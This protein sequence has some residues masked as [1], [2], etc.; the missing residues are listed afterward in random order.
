MANF[1]G[2][3]GALPGVIAE[4]ETNTRGQSIPGATRTAALMG[5]GL[6]VERLINSAVGGGNDGLNSTYSSKNGR[7]GRHFLLSSV[8]VVSNRTVLF[9]NGVPLVGVE[10]PVSSTPVG[11]AYDYRLD[12]ANGQIELKGANLVDL[13]GKLYLASTSNQGNGTIGTL[14]L[15]DKNAPTETWTVRCLSVRKD[16][17]GAPIDGYAKFIAQGS[18]SGVPLDGYGNQITWSSNGVLVSN[19]VLSFSV[20]EGTNKFNIGDKFTVKV[21][22]GA[23]TAGESLVANYIAITD[24]NDPEFFTDINLLAAKHGTPSLTNRLSLGAQLAFAN[25]PPGVWTVQTAPAIPRRVSYLLEQSASGNAA[26]NDLSFSLPLDVIPDTNSN[27]NL[28]V[29]DPVTGIET[30]L[31]PNKVAFY[32]AS[33]STSPSL[34]HFGALY[35]FS[36]TVVLDK[37]HDVIAKRVDGVLTAGKLSSATYTFTAT[38]VTSGR[39]VRILTPNVNAG[40]YTI[41]SVNLGVATLT[42]LSTTSSVIEFE[43]LEAS[44]NST[45][46]V[47]FTKDLALSAGS[48][49]RATIVDQRDAT[50]FDVG[51]AAAYEALEIIQTNIVVPLPSQTIS[52]IFASGAAHV[53]AMSQPKIKR[54]RHLYIGAI[55]GLKPEHVTG[56]TPA[57][58]EDVGVLEG[59]QG[60]DVSEVLSGNTE[61]LTNYGAQSAFGNTFRVV[62]FYPDEIVVQIG[63]DRV[64]VDG[65]FMAAAA[66]GYLSSVAS[67]AIPLTNKVLAGF[68]ILRNRMFR[69]SVEETIANAGI[70]LVRPVAGGGKVVWGRTTTISGFP[71]EE[72]ISIVFIRDRIAELMRKGFE[73]Y[74]GVAEDD[75]TL[76]SMSARAIG[77]FKSFRGSLITS[78]SDVKVVK[79]SVDPRQYNVV[80]NVVPRYGIN[81]VYIKIGIGTN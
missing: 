38:D 18:V 73:G 58:V 19:G 52:A 24:L 26:V 65:F 43:V 5:E 61:D 22:G 76:G 75:T 30:Q 10:E 62:Y 33:I 60:D 68:T 6:R 32:D 20:S 69:P 13:G 39:S 3:E 59:I 4:V 51:W 41:A 31:V 23:L 70:C 40:V 63:A 29:K 35:N 48:S 77:L 27:I 50:F 7:D 25:S 8:P 81:N 1:P 64:F 44:T 17:Y 49:L 21:A 66:A 37:V 53:K 46:R 9:K 14:T 34:F 55:R 47:L 67:V 80:G 42:G 54:E 79:D 15:Q 57:A 36:Y 78:F 56:V 28:F 12:I 16:G 71:E 45:A 72:E 2:G 74:P 11:A